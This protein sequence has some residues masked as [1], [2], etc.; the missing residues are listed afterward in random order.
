MSHRHD[1]SGHSSLA[2]RYT[3]V[4]QRT[5]RL[6]EP[7]T[8]EDCN[9]QSM[10]DASPVKWHLAHTAWFFETFLLTTRATS[11]RPFNPQFRFLFNS[12]YQNVGPRWTRAKRGLLS[13]PTL[14]E[15]LEYRQ[16]VDRA[17]LNMM[18]D[19]ATDPSTT[20]VVEL[21]LNHEQQH[22]ELILTDVKHALGQNPLR[23]VYQPREMP[24]PSSVA[25]GPGWRAFP[26]QI[27]EIGHAG[28]G[29]CFD[30]EQ[31]CHRVLLAA[32]EMASRLVTAGE[33]QK[34]IE[35]GG[36]QRP[37][38]WL[39]DG[40]AKC[41]AE[42]WTAPLYWE[43]EE[44]GWHVFT[45]SGYRPVEDGEPVVH[46]SFYEADAYARWADARLPTEFEW[47]HAA[48][49]QALAGHFLESEHFH[50][51]AVPAVDDEG[52]L[53]QLHGDAW[54][55]TGSA[56]LGY[57]GYRPLPGAL[58]EYNGKFMCNQMVLRGSSCATPK[59]H[60]RQTYRN[61]FPAEARWQFV[62]IRLCRSA[63]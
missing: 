53:L 17:M 16:H 42:G 38:L 26:E 5:E 50:P 41:Q 3:S 52:P 9:L 35:D 30:N 23:P 8:A 28:S 36:Y 44:T 31:P 56:Y 39:S 63:I 25:A 40:W 58:G 45:L 49:Q 14:A 43:K 18:E 22:Q 10:P 61:F 21:G 13:R 11:Y 1:L 6:A 51:A 46:V 2:L 59:S 54:Q 62:G 29:F 4:R 34:F 48:R 12:Y 55:W 7:L 27:V 20:A 15:V 24:S 47:E 57:P 33:Y 32:F 19:S 60:A 37:E